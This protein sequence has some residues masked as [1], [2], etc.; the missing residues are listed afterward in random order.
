MN[1]LICFPHVQDVSFNGLFVTELLMAGFGAG[2]R[3]HL[4]AFLV[5]IEYYAHFGLFAF[6]AHFLS[7]HFELLDG[8]DV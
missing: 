2:K 1:P 7:S 6:C 5:S 4:L 3:P 8:G